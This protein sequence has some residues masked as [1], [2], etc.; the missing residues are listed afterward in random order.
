V[1]TIQHIALPLPLLFCPKQGRYHTTKADVLIFMLTQ[2][3]TAF[4]RAGIDISQLPLTMDSAYV[5]QELRQRLHQL[6]LIDSIM[7]GKGNDVLTIDTQKWDASTWKKVLMLEEPTWGIDVPSCRLWGSSPT[8]GSLILCFFR[9]STTRSSYL[10]HFSQ[11][12]L[13]GAEIWHIW[14]QHHVIES[15]WK[16]MKAIFQLRSMHLQGDGLYTALLIKVFAYLLALRLQAQG[17]FSKLTLTEIMRQ[18]R[19]EADLRDCLATHFHA[20]FSIG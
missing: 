16:I 8:C 4:L 7:A 5:S 2:L 3:K 15:F 18:L 13:R 9:K 20:P 19:R 1:F 12:S 10:M 17:V 11:R 6:G 14:K